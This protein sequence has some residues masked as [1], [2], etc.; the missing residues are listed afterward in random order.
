MKERKLTVKEI[1][2]LTDDELEIMM[3]QKEFDKMHE[4]GLQYT[5]QLL[6]LLQDNVRES[7]QKE[8]EEHTSISEYLDYL[9]D[10]SNC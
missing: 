5:W 4:L 8:N 1:L 9:E 10:M 6:D 7:G 3:T 2:N